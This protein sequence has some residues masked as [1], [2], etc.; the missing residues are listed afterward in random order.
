M[1]VNYHIKKFYTIG[2]GI[3]TE[4]LS[5]VALLNKVACF[6]KKENNILNIKMS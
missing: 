3:L 6:V 2:E 4:G 5:T 1:A